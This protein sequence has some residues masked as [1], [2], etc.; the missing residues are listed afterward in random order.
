MVYSRIIIV[1]TEQTLYT[2]ITDAGLGYVVI[3]NRTHLSISLIVVPVFHHKYVARAVFLYLRYKTV[4]GVVIRA[5]S[6]LLIH[7]EENYYFM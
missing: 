3:R 1:D 2:G 4:G 5:L 7:D 6:V